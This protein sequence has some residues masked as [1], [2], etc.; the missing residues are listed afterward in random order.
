MCV[1]M[2]VCCLPLRKFKQLLCWKIYCLSSP[3]RN[4]TR[5][6]KHSHIKL[7]SFWGFLLYRKLKF[8]EKVRERES[9]QTEIEFLSM[10]KDKSG[11]FWKEKKKICNFVL[12]K[13]TKEFLNFK[14]LTHNSQFLSSFFPHP[15]TVQLVPATS[16]FM[17]AGGRHTGNKW[18]WNATRVASCE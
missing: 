3:H 15:M 1:S 5:R 17:S 9:I 2:F 7:G 6:K 14:V 11:S 16:S 10:L 8:F 12:L 4:F 13:C 18:S